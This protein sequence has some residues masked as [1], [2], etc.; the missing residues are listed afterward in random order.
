[1]GD[2]NGHKDKKAIKVVEKFAVNRERQV[3]KFAA[4]GGAI[5]DIYADKHKK[6]IKGAGGFTVDSEK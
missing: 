1:M 3:N 4:K 5:I 2:K 6:E